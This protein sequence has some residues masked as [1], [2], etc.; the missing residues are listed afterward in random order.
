ML[1]KPNAT[2]T[3]LILAKPTH[4][5][6]IQHNLILPNPTQRNLLYKTKHIPSEPNLLVVVC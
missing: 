3:N 1:T 4:G 5:N 2:E 6:E